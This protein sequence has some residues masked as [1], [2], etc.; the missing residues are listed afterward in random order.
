MREDIQDDFLWPPLIVRGEG[1]TGRVIKA[2]IRHDPAL[3]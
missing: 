2:L 3:L 1:D